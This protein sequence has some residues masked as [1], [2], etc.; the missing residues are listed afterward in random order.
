MPSAAVFG[1]VADP[2]SPGNSTV[3]AEND[4]TR[5]V[6]D[7]HPHPSATRTSV[8]PAGESNQHLYPRAEALRVL[9]IAIGDFFGNNGILVADG[10]GC[11]QLYLSWAI[12][13]YLLRAGIPLQDPLCR[14]ACQME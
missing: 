12:A 4:S 8:M 10:K 6:F 1:G 7:A 5:I 9:R 14:L 2:T 11:C 13:T 3:Y